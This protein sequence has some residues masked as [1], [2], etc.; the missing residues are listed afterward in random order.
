MYEL[1]YTHTILCCQLR[2]PRSNDTPVAMST[3]MASSG[4][5]IPFP[6]ERN[7]DPLENWLILEVGQEICKMSLEHLAVPEGK[8]VGIH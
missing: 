1:V 7:Q 6:S 8:D 3:P 2:G 5:L 4:L